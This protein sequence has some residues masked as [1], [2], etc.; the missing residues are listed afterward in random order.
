MSPPD[1]TADPTDSDA[2]A[3]FAAGLYRIE[4]RAL[5]DGDSGARALLARLRRA[6]SRR[7]VE[8]TALA[9]VGDLLPWTGGEP[10]ADDVLDTYLLV[11]ALYAV[12]ASGSGESRGASEGASFGTAANWLQK[13]LNQ[14]KR[15]RRH[16]GLD[17]RFGA[18][19]DA[20]R[21]DLPYRLRQIVSM[22]AAHP[23]GL[24]TDQLLY[25]LLRWDAPGR[26][27]QRRWARDYW[28]GSRSTPTPTDR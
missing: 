13:E 3:R 24:R 8:P 25:D 2:C 27:V 15:D 4:Q 10:L 19:L 12:R 26:A 7:G 16:P 22:M 20:R 17:L 5:K 23:V 14:G 1:T 28:T 9:E 21:E 18:L 11:A 6:L